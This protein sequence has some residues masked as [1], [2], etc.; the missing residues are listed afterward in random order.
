MGIESLPTPEKKLIGL[1]ANGEKVI[2]RPRS[3]VHEFS[4][5]FRENLQITLSEINANGEDFI[6]YTKEFDGV[7]GLNHCV[8]TG[9]DENEKVTYAIREGRRGYT[10]FIRDLQPIPTNEMTVILKAKEDI[11]NTYV[12]I[13][14]FEGPTAAKEPWDPTATDED[15]RFW[16]NHALIWDPDLFPFVPGT[17]RNSRPEGY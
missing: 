2:D 12:L 15:R 3:H 7:I 10:R 4:P 5:N 9:L 17:V 14:A 1:L 16:E 6:V 13:T 11:P 8:E